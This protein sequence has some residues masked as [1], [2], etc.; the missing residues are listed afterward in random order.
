MSAFPFV[1]FLIYVNSFIF[2]FGAGILFSTLGALFRRFTGQPVPQ[3][4]GAV[5]GAFSGALVS[6]FAFSG[7]LSYLVRLPA[8]WGGV[9]GLICG[10]LYTYECDGRFV[11]IWGDDAMSKA[12]D[13]KVEAAATARLTEFTRLKTDGALDGP[14]S[15]C[16]CCNAFI[17]QDLIKCPNCQ[18]D[19][20]G[21]NIFKVQ[22]IS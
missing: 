7:S 21:L 11:P 22:S 6:Y 12:E 5:M 2:S 4:L 19:F 14:H 10:W 15:G 18:F 1:L 9:A 3:W 16:P 17:A 13:E 20:R 8:L